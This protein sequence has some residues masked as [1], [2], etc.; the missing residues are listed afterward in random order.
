MFGSCLPI[1]RRVADTVGEEDDLFRIGG[2]A[3]QIRGVLPDH[4]QPLIKGNPME[5]ALDLTLQ[6]GWRK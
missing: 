2:R 4:A 3:H 5:A 1:L 6:G